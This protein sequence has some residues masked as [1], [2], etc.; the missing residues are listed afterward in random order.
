[1]LQLRLL[2]PFEL[3]R[4]DGSGVSLPGRQSMAILACLGLA[5][6]FSVARERLAELERN[7]IILYRP[8]NHRI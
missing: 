7:P 2:G 5:D 6:D 3:R 4:V 1:M 8:D